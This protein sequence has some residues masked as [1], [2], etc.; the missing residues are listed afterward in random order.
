M[1]NIPTSKHLKTTAILVGLFFTGISSAAQNALPAPGNTGDDSLYQ[2]QFAPNQKIAHDLL[3]NEKM[4]SPTK[5]SALPVKTFSVSSNSAIS[6][7]VKMPA[8]T[9]SSA[10]NNAQDN[11]PN[12]QLAHYLTFDEKAPHMTFYLTSGVIATDLSNNNNVVIDQYNTVNT[13]NTNVK[14]NFLFGAGLGMGYIQYPYPFENFRMT[15]APA[16]YY[17]DMGTVSGIEHPDSSGGDF[18]TLNY[19]FDA[20]S[21]ALLLET[22]LAYTAYAW[23]PVFVLG[24]GGAENHLQNYSEY[25][26]D[27]NG[28]ASPTT[29]PFGNK[30]STNF[31]YEVGVGISHPIFVGKSRTVA[32]NIGLDYRYFYFGS[33][34]LGASAGGDHLKV[35]TMSAQAILLSLGM[36]FN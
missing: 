18:D 8:S 13:Y 11:A 21:L 31:A 19:N 3:R 35:N 14:W 27:S 2:S 4:S 15:I 9:K 26:T 32:Y 20:S 29:A 34:E 1:M 33:G 24:V 12:S 5:V 17:A 10:L 36:S 16:F 7:T 28:S 22:H 25:A 23:Q 6:T 30:W